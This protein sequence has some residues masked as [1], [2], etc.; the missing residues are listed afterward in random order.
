MPRL[1]KIASMT[2]VLAAVLAVPA[3]QAQ[4]PVARPQPPPPPPN[5]KAPATPAKPG[6]TTPPPVSQQPGAQPQIAPAA[7][8][9]AAQ[10]ATSFSATAEAPPAACQAGAPVLAGAR[11]LAAYDAGMGQTYCL[12]GSTQA[13]TDVVNYYRT[14]LK[15]RGDLVFDAPATHMFEVGRFKESDVA[16]PPGVTVKDYTFGGAPGYMN[17][18]PGGAPAFFPTIIQVVP[19]PIK[20]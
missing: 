9:S 18:T 17:P 19:P 5:A 12:Y 1:W 3:A 16:F 15:D 10:A 2:L 8:P 20:R 14:V 4:P 13:F 11:Y 7:A 6:T